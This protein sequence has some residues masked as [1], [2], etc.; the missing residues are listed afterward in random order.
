MRTIT[1]DTLL[2]YLNCKHRAFLEATAFPGEQPDFERVQLDLDRLYR[3]QALESYLAAHPGCVIV[4]DPRSFQE[5]VHGAPDFIVDATL[6]TENACCRLHLAERV[7]RVP[8]TRTAV[9]AP[10]LFVRK[11]KV[12]AADRLLLALHALL[13]SSVQGVPAPF[14]RLVHGGARQIIRVRIEPFV[15]KVRGLLD[16]IARTLAGDA[17]PALTLNRHCTVCPFQD[18]CRT[19]AQQTDDLSLLRGLSEAEIEKHRSRGITTIKQL[20]YAYQPGRRGKRKREGA[21]RHDPAL[22]ALAIREQKVYVVDPPD[23]PTAGAALYLDV[24]GV[25]E[26]DFYYLI[27]LVAVDE[28]GCTSYSFWADDEGQCLAAWQA[29]A[30][31]IQSYAR[32]TLYHYGQ[33]ELRFLDRMQQLVGEEGRAA[34]EGIRANCCNVLASVYSHV[35]FPTYSNGLKDIGKFLGAEWSAPRASGIQSLAWRLAWESSREEALKQELVRYNQEDCR[36]LR[37]VTEFVAALGPDA[38]RR[39]DGGPAV[40][41][42]PQSGSFWF[43]KTDFFCPE[44]AHI[45]KCAYSDYQRERVYFRTSPTVRKSLR[46][47]E[48]ASGKKRLRVNQHV[49]CGRPERCPACGG[50]VAPAS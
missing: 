45:H 24:E 3:R 16:E 30:Q 32:Y 13:L 2:S 19:V 34:L 11:D 50:V 42:A 40:D 26:R 39:R 49:E 6:T 47:K 21:R 20:S 10:V 46:R 25:P 33:Y 5:A 48:R 15:R 7:E 44:L 14:G 29:C 37:R 35:Y 9:Y 41:S 17:A 43:R 38:T 8:A 4:R 27:G 18:A 22:Q 12:T 36:A 28:G 31:V 23:L 1:D